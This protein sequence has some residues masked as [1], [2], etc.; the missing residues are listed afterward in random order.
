VN[1]LNTSTHKKFKTILAVLVCISN[2][3]QIFLF[4]KIPKTQN[5]NFDHSIALIILIFQKEAVLG[6]IHT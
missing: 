5:A 3:R 4:A 1:L 2:Q 6:Q